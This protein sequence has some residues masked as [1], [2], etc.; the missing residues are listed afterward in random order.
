MASN[1]ATATAVTRF[2]LNELTENGTQ[3]RIAGEKARDMATDFMH[4]IEEGSTSDAH[5][6][7]D[8]I[9]K[10]LDMHTGSVQMRHAN[11]RSLIVQSRDILALLDAHTTIGDDMWK[12][13]CDRLRAFLVLLARHI[14]ANIQTK[15]SGTNQRDDII[16]D[17]LRGTRGMIAAIGRTDIA[18]MPAGP[19]LDALNAVKAAEKQRQEKRDQQKAQ[20]DAAQKQLATPASTAAD[21]TPDAP[22]TAPVPAQPRKRG[23]GTHTA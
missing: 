16:S 3:Q 21:S 15:K 4:S 2:S 18:F 22:V 17:M 10:A 12:Q 7:L 13:Y 23:K 1:I 6:V 19:A 9:E 20:L 14:P 11:T 5:A 8:A